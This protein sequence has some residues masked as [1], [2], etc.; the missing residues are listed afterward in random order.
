MSND[1]KSMYRRH[2]VSSPL[3]WHITHVAW[4][5]QPQH[6][7]DYAV[8]HAPQVML[9]R[10]HPIYTNPLLLHYLTMHGDDEVARQLAPQLVASAINMSHSS[11]SEEMATVARQIIACRGPVQL[12]SLARRKARQQGL[13][14]DRV[15]GQFTLGWIVY[16]YAEF[17][18]RMYALVLRAA[19]SSSTRR[20]RSS[21]EEAPSLYHM[22]H[23]RHDG[24][25]SYLKPLKV[26]TT[27][28]TNQNHKSSV[29]HLPIVLPYLAWFW[30]MLNVGAQIP[31]RGLRPSSIQRRLMRW[32]GPKKGSRT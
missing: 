28:T 6:V 2:H 22:M 16:H 23:I 21:D 15:L 24:N 26:W 12:E 3:P 30:I 14:T 10:N 20:R 32:L 4:F 1:C 9:A 31:K 17:A 19:A 27:T 25:R 18:R 7:I 13:Y 8:I 5:D 11:A 29:S